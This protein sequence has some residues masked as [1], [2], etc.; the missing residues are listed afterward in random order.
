VTLQRLTLVLL[1]VAALA[2]SIAACG[3]GYQDA[4]AGTHGWKR[5]VP[6]GDCE[7]SDGSQF[8]F[9]VR[10]AN[11]TKVV[12]YLQGGGACWSA[13]T[14]ASGREVYNRNIGPDDGPIGS[15]GMFD[16][17]D[18]RNPFADYSVV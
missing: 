1:V 15:K 18:R 9:W 3:D 12:F 16:F 6:G 2:A 10:K 5:V 11:P 4:A 8:S 7:C 17:A 14:C 13:Q